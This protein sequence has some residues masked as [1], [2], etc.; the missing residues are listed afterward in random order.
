MD[1]TL[2]AA[3]AKVLSAALTPAP[4]AP[5]YSTG[6]STVDAALRNDS[7]TVST[8]GSRASTTSTRN[9]TGQR[10]SATPDR[11]IPG[12]SSDSPAQAGVQW[13]LGLALLGAV[14]WRL[15]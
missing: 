4:A 6:T 12:L 13:A 11:G 8:S 7:W 10:V 3:G 15:R 14:L 9:D 1:P 2:I 5:S